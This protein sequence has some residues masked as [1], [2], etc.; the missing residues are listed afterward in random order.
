MNFLV[1][2]QRNKEKLNYKAKFAKTNRKIKIAR[3]LKTPK[4]QI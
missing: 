2:T 4:C 1:H 3:K